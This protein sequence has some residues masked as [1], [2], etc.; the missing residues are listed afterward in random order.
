MKMR[1]AVMKVILAEGRNEVALSPNEMEWVTLRKQWLKQAKAG[2]K[3]TPARIMR[4]MCFQAIMHKA[5]QYTN[6]D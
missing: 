4:Q 6:G 3:G 2:P 5:R 1:Q